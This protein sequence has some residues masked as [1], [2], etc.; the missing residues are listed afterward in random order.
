MSIQER[1]ELT[2][3]LALINK[4]LQDE[5]LSWEKSL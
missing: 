2:S 4:E 3:E 5:S 1:A